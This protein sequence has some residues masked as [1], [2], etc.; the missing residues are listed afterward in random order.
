MRGI[1]RFV[2]LVSGLALVA[3]LASAQFGIGKKKD[4]EQVRADQ[5][6]KADKAAK[7]YD[8]LKE[9]SENLYAS[10]LDFREDVEKHYDQV[11][12][13]HSEEAFQNNI[14][15]PARPT[16]VHDGDRLR[17]QTGLYDNKLVADY[18]NRIGQQLVPE[19]SE[20][21][22]AFR[23]V[24]H[25]VPFANTLSTGTIYIS[26]GLISM[27]D[28]EAQL[29]YVLSHE[30]GHVYKDHWKLK[31]LMEVGEEE[32]NKKQ[33]KKRRL[34]ALGAGIA[35]AGITGGLTRS[36]DNAALAG[37]LGAGAAYGLAH[38]F[39]QGM[40]L[41]WDKV[42]EDEADK[43]AFK[44]AL[45]R[46][47]DVQEVPKLY[48]AI[49]NQV[50]RDQRV[51]LGFMGSRRR[52]EERIANVNDLLKGD[53]KGEID[54]RMKQGKLMGS[55]PEFSLVM[56]EL[57]RDNGILAFYHDMFQLAKSNLEY[58]VAY[59]SND[60]GTH[61]YYAKVLKLVGRNE[62]DKKQAENEFIKAASTDTR[63][64]YYGAHLYHAIFLMNQ[65]DPS[66]NPK[67]VEELQA[68][69]NSYL[70]YTS[71]EAILAG[72]LPA[73][74][75]DL[76]DYME[77]AGEVKWN[78]KIPAG[79]AARLAAFST[80]SGIVLPARGFTESAPSAGAS[81]TADGAAGNAR[82]KNAATGSAI[83]AGAGLVTGG[84]KGM[85]TGAAVG[86][87]AGAATT[88]KTPAKKQ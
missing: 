32:F 19:D 27:L 1:R 29:A 6:K 39:I 48:M 18:V 70:G 88:K 11:Q 81:P 14:A 59:R 41:D 31:S 87:A 24:A 45:N 74:L 43:I 16:V 73:N 55:S 71:E 56:S 7:Q 23:L 3:G 28:N 38:V 35:A 51:G 68:Y 69:L 40:N 79:T 84:A 50:H 30:M 66:Q 17:L 82:L 33:E 44:A 52:L 78:P 77:Q 9:F 42:Q 61:Y 10:D 15:P 36:G 47:Y 63:S 53:Y 12:Q 60:P 86:A 49:Q 67:I 57:K 83:G 8:K 65:K 75:D 2:T 20:K 64:R 4:P 37:V 46:N 85:V 26:T 80:D 62:E 22:F 13:Q 34:F 5:L 21:L 25:P 54:Q 76:Y 58:A 72:Y